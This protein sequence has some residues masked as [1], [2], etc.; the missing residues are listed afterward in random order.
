M[1]LKIKFMLF[2]TMRYTGPDLRTCFRIEKLDE[3]MLIASKDN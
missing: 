2:E 3:T 1:I